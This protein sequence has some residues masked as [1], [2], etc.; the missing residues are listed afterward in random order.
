M[1]RSILM[2]LAMTFTVM[3]FV[4]STFAAIT[5]TIKNAD[6]SAA[7]AAVVYTLNSST[8]AETI[9]A[10]ADGSGVAT[11]SPAAGKLFYLIRNAG[12][13]T[14][15]SYSVDYDGVGPVAAT[16]SLGTPFDP[17]IGSYSASRTN[18][19]VTIGKTMPFWVYPSPIHNPGY[20]APSAAFATIATI[21]ANL[22]SSFAW[23][24]TGNGTLND[25]VGGS[26]AANNNYV[27]VNT[28]GA[29]DGNTIALQVIET[30]AP[31][32]GGCAATPVFFNFEA[33]NPPYAR[34]SNTNAG[35]LY[36][37]SGVAIK[38]IVSGCTPTAAT[39]VTVALDNAKEL[40]P[41][42]LRL[43]YTAQNAHLNTLLADD[44]ILDAPVLTFPAGKEPIGMDAINPSNVTTNPFKFAAAG[45]LYAAATTFT[46]LNDKITVYKFDLGSWNASISR[47]SDYKA[48]SAPLSI[49]TSPYTWYTGGVAGTSGQPAADVTVAYI[50]VFPK[51]VTGPIYHIA[52]SWGII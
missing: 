20:T 13:T 16:V 44:L 21:D 7:G 51:P 1:K 49:A 52:N 36:T 31:S 25:N 19:R 22:S 6:G 14:Y 28:T 38:T 4:S 15:A 35:L 3:L 10:T 39:N 17:T 11:W 18:D 43:T 12:N 27:E 26:D 9:A 24:K 40:F 37:I 2:K 34:I 32:Y 47:K 33:I 23:V 48:L 8:G 42:Y 30:P 5:L 46:T 29:T 50:I 45:N 41:Y